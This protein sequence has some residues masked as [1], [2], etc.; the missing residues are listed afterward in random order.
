MCLPRRWDLLGTL[1]HLLFWAKGTFL[2]GKK[3]KVTLGWGGASSSVTVFE[4]YVYGFGLFLCSSL[5]F[6]K[7]SFLLA[8]R[9]GSCLSYR[10]VN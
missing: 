6:K 1:C 5:V 2:C 9:K 8:L 10:A 7:T 4:S 3:V